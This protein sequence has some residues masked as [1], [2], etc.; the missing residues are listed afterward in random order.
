VLI[1]ERYFSN[2]APDDGEEDSDLDADGQEKVA[3]EFGVKGVNSGVDSVDA[4]GQF[5]PEPIDLVVEVDDQVTEFSR[6]PGN[7][8]QFFLPGRRRVLREWA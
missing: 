4:V 5:F 6:T 1:T 2:N 8:P 3:G 7:V